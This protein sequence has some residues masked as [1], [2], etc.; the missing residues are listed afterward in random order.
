MGGRVPYILW[1]PT[2]EEAQEVVSPMVRLSLRRIAI[3]RSSELRNEK[4]IQSVQKEY[5][6]RRILADC[7][8]SAGFIILE[9]MDTGFRHGSPLECSTV[10]KVG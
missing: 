1:I 4:L 10:E 9:L 5:V 3:R 6:V 7:H 8:G 2:H